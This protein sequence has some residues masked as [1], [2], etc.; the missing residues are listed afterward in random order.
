MKFWDASA[1]VLLCLEQP[2]SSAARALLA[3]DRSMV[4]WWGSLVECWSAFARLRREGV[5]VPQREETARRMLQVLQD[6]W[7]E[8]T[9][10]EEVRRQAGRLLR[11]HALHASD[12][13][14]LAAALLWAGTPPGGEIV[15]FDH[16]LAVAA[17]LEGLT[18]RP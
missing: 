7:V 11:L 16:R 6:A 2:S 13:L 14:Q 1:L 15:V 3:E 10:G 8:I 17:R 12:A 18:P 9:P 5:L 4:V